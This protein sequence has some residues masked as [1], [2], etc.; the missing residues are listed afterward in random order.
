MKLRTFQAETMAAALK[1]VKQELGSSAVILHTRTFKRGGI[2]GLGARQVVEITASDDVNVP[3]RTLRRT[4]APS[5]SAL[6]SKQK[7]G[8]L[9]NQTYKA[10]NSRALA[11]AAASVSPS[12]TTLADPHAVATDAHT[13]NETHAP[14][15]TLNGNGEGGV[16]GEIRQIRAMVDRMMRKQSREHATSLPEKLFNEYLT[17]IEQDVA[18]E[19][20]EEIVQ[21]VLKAVPAEQI[22][23]EKVVRE[24]ISKQVADLIP[25]DAEPS[26]RAR[27]KDGRPLTIALIGPTG[28]GKTTTLAKLAAT[29]KLRQ[30]KKVAMITIDTY[31]I[32]AVEQLKT[33]AEIIKVPLHTVLSPEDLGDALA[34]CQDCDVVLIDTAGRSQR[35]DDKLLDLQRFIDVAHPHEVHLVLSSTCSQRV[36]MEAVERFTQLQVDRVI[37][38]KL[39]EAVNFG[40]LLNVVRRVNKQLSYV[41]TGQEVPHQ[42]EPG[43]SARLAGLILGERV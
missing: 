8:N 33:Y 27:P 15:Q 40:V 13:L 35:D 12:N 22:D 34:R 39:D 24:A 38:T 20:A 28:V 3:A 4:P 36:L 30:K 41:T 19:L 11:S 6:G 25:V 17:L 16:G 14:R 26:T 23:D 5:T 32:A 42:I 43:S 37:F 18:E 31:R 7:I 10:S 1:Q 21:K 29:L 9:L 2:M